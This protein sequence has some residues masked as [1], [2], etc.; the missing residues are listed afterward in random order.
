[1]SKE[2]SCPYCGSAMRKSAKFC[3]KCGKKTEDSKL[4]LE[5]AI[6]LIKKGDNFLASPFP[7]RAIES[8]SKALQIVPTLKSAWVGKGKSLCKI[9]HWKEAKDCFIKALELDA[10]DPDALF[11][12]AYCEENLG[13]KS[14]S[15]K[16]YEDILKEPNIP[17]KQIQHVKTR[18]AEWNS[19]PISSPKSKLSS[20]SIFLLMLGL[21]LVLTSLFL[22]TYYETSTQN[23][24]T[25]GW[26]LV[27][28]PNVN[29]NPQMPQLPSNPW[30]YGQVPVPTQKEVTTYPYSQFGICSA[31]GGI[32][33]LISGIILLTTMKIR[34][35]NTV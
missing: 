20:I 24:Y 30:H 22:L 21:I 35:K 5:H 7:G 2:G 25:T 4:T 19:R 31:V 14:E 6:A 1:M 9:K 13:L 33:L 12:K 27:P 11:G 32:I 29:L 17:E 10:K 8:Y 23:G 26:S 34:G 28:N 18:L 16:A 3:A 15:K